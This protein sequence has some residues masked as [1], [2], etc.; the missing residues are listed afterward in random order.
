MT[1]QVNTDNNIKGSQNMEAYF[2][3]KI[4]TGLKHFAD[5]ITR[6]EVHLSDQNGEKSGTNDIQCRLEARLEGQQPILAESREENHE[7]ALSKA[8]SKMQAALRT[9]I[10]KMQNNR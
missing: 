10:G 9:K 3:E 5:H 2:T 7:K 4:E 1:I 8:I 6:V